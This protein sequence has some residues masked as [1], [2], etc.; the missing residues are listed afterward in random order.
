MKNQKIRELLDQLQEEL[1]RIDSQDEKGRRL[2]NNI[3]ADIN[4]L[5]EDSNYRPDEPILQRLQDTIDHF[6][7]EHPTLTM[8]LSEMLAI[9]SNAG[10]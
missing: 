8:A 4:S 2:L 1:D 3:S 9:L 5:L 6:K 10:I 7:V